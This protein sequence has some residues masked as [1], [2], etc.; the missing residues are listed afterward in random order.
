M[1]L[2]IDPNQVKDLIGHLEP[3]QGDD[4]P[5]DDQDTPEKKKDEEKKD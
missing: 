1:N 2:D 4:E 3:A 5:D